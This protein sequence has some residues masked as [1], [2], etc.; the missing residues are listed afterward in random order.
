M[1]VSAPSATITGGMIART[2]KYRLAVWSGWAITIL[3]VGILHLMD[4]ETSVVKWIFLN[5]ASGIGI[6]ILFSSLAI[7]AQASASD[8]EM[9]TAASL[10]PFFRAL[11]QSLGIVLGSAVFQNQMKKHLSS[12]PELRDKAAEYAI[13]AVGLAQKIKKMPLQSLERQHIIDSYVSSLRILWYTLMALGIVA[14][15]ASLFTSALSLDRQSSIEENK[16]GEDL[17]HG[18]EKPDTETPDTETPD[19]KT[20]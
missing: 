5:A 2:G 9:A 12:Y 15:L 19:T 18:K 13:D 3:G 17:E 16:I 14:G 8:A 6:G 7:A 1:V 20:I 11:G 10:N 4:A